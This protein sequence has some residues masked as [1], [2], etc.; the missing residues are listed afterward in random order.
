MGAP[1]LLLHVDLDAATLALAFGFP[2]QARFGVAHAD[3]DL[4]GTAEQGRHQA[5]HA[6]LLIEQLPDLGGRLDQGP[7]GGLHAPVFAD[8]TRPPAPSS[9]WAI[10]AAQAW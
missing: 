6:F 5:L 8:R 4:R 7:A 3:L 1:A 2:D 9:R 10:P